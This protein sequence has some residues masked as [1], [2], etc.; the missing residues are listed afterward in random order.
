MYGLS[1]MCDLYFLYD[2]LHMHV[3]NNMQVNKYIEWNNIFLFYVSD[4]LSFILFWSVVVSIAPYL[5]CMSKAFYLNL[6]VFLH[7][8]PCPFVLVV[9]MLPCHARWSLYAMV[10]VIN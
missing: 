1:F 9:A 7:I 2:L 3:S 8:C 4:L 5:S 6:S 10:H